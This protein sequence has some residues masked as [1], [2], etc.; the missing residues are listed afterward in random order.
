MVPA[1]KIFQDQGQGGCYSK[2]DLFSFNWQLY[3]SLLVFRVVKLY[4]IWLVVNSSDTSAGRLT[5]ELSSQHF[6][7][8][9]AMVHMVQFPYHSVTDHQGALAVLYSM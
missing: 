3:L 7:G 2:K 1:I 5:T 4:H 8:P 6:S 9:E